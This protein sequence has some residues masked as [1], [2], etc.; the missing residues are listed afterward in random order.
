[1]IQFFVCDGC[2]EI[3]YCDFVRR[4]G[5][6]LSENFTQRDCRVFYMLRHIFRP[7]AKPRIFQENTAP[8]YAVHALIFLTVGFFNRKK[9]GLDFLALISANP[10]TLPLSRRKRP[11]LNGHLGWR[12]IR[13]GD[14]H[15]IF[16][17]LQVSAR[18]RLAFRQVQQSQ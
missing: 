11:R 1:M 8:P 10:T 2:A 15:Q 5:G 7:S 17:T 12:A 6:R 13:W 9:R 3:V 4:R 14:S 18:T 16:G